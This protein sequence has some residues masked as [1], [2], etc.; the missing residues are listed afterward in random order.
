M[1]LKELAKKSIEIR[2]ALIEKYDVLG[3]KEAIVN[4]EHSYSVHVWHYEKL[5]GL[6]DGKDVVIEERDCEEYP[7]RAITITNDNLRL[8]VILKNE[9]TN[10]FLEEAQKN[11]LTI[12]FK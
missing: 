8:Y 10:T 3:V 2:D 6:S 11:G 9:E 7:Y 12:K 4:G 1:S 5:I